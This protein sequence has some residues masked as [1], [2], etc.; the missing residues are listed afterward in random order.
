MNKILALAASL[1]L[2]SPAA[3]QSTVLVITG[4]IN[5]ITDG[6]N[7]SCPAPTGPGQI[8]FNNVDIYTFTHP[9]A[10][11]PSTPPPAPAYLK[12][13]GNI[14]GTYDAAHYSCPA[15][16]FVGQV[17]FN[18]VD[19]YKYNHPVIA[20]TITPTP[21]P[22]PSAP[23]APPAPVVTTVM[24]PPNI[25]P[26]IP[27]I[28]PVAPV[29]SSTAPVKNTKPV[30]VVALDPD[31]SKAKAAAADARKKKFEQLGRKLDSLTGRI[32]HSM[33]SG[34][35]RDALLARV[36]NLAAQFKDPASELTIDAAEDAFKKLSDDFEAASESA[37]PER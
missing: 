14:D 8:F 5:G 7:Y 19:I 1:W 3:A 28:P 22:A 24:P 20:P 9:S 2:A 34:V 30:V 25:T 33:I 21:P 16:Q 27:S 11:P 18:G 10:T 35:K 26:P 6:S 31:G 12:I 13:V 4:S 36:K 23:A 32:A 29:A 17:I 15:P 37:H